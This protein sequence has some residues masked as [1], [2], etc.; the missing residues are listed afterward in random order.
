[1]ASSEA[2]SDTWLAAGVIS[3]TKMLENGRKL[4]NSVTVT[5]RTLAQME[6][7]ALRYVI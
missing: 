3:R 7:E 5:T 1:M 2:C 6:L 4:E